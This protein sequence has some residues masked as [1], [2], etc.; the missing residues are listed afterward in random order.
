MSV[1]VRFTHCTTQVIEAMFGIYYATVVC[2]NIKLFHA[3]I[4][5]FQH[6]RI[7]LHTF[8]YIW[9]KNESISGKIIMFKNIQEV[10][11][12]SQSAINTR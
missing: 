12:F 8:N 11:F 7:S 10:T 6:E 4:K 9:N 1:T 2:T 5:Y 3:E